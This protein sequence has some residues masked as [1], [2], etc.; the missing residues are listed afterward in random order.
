MR[1]SKRNTYSHSLTLED[2]I[3]ILSNFN[4]KHKFRIFNS[5][6]T[7]LLGQVNAGARTIELSDDAIQAEKYLVIIHELYH[8]YDALHGV[9]SKERTTNKRTNRT[10]KQLYR[11][12]FELY[13]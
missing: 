7:Q 2:V 10:Y 11:N 4:V 5:K 1:T 9:N 13:I 6:G 8:A 12:K 3:E